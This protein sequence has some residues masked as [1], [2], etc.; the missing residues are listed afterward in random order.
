MRFLPA[1]DFDLV[2]YD[3]FDLARFR[4]LRR[5][6]KGGIALY[7]FIL[8]KKH[9]VVLIASRAFQQLESPKLL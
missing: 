2:I 4:F 5:A 9:M 7:T 8:V 3:F 1:I 6:Q